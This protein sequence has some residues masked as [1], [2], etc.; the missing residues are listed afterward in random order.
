MNAAMLHPSEPLPMDVRLM[1]WAAW[2]LAILACLAAMTMFARWTLAHPIFGIARIVVEGDTSHHSSV[3]LQANV[4]SRISGNFFTTDLAQVRNVFESVPWVRKAT[5]R[6]EFPN[7]LRITIEE[8]RSVGFW[9]ADTES[10]MVNTHGEIFEANTGEAETDD[11]P[12]LVGVDN[13]SQQMLK[14]YR[15]LQSVF[16][17]F[18]ATVEQLNLSHQGSWALLLD[19]GAE[20]ELGLGSTEQVLARLNKF[21]A[22]Q[23]QVLATYQRAGLDRIESVDL[24]HAQGYAIRMRGVSTT[25][26]VPEAR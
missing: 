25:A 9:G 18:D 1:N 24:R 5:V 16:K 20:M 26:N 2:G 14:M 8:H 11:L 7:R 10:R 4:G 13:Q 12:R 17:P 19:S 6:R 21:L 23:R 15:Q 22:T 3:S